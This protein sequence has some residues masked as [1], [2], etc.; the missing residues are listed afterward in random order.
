MVALLRGGKGAKV[1]KVATSCRIP[2]LGTLGASHFHVKT[3]AHLA[4]IISAI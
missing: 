1:A 4:K 2:L 3:S